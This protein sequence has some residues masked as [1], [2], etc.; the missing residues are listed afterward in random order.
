MS[1]PS[2]NLTYQIVLGNGDLSNV[3]SPIFS[4]GDNVRIIATFDPSL[5]TSVLPSITLDPSG[6]IPIVELQKMDASGSDG[7][8]Y[9]YDYLIP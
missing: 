6:T 5:S 1:D 8:T 3:T 7:I 9:Y 2:A 4:G